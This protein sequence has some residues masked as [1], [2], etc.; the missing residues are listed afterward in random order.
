V[1]G[2]GFFVVAASDFWRRPSIASRL[3]H[4]VFGAMCRELILDPSWDLFQL[5]VVPKEQ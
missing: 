3:C 4:F 5:I 1:C 2:I